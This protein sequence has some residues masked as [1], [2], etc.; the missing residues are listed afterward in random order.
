M[1]FFLRVTHPTGGHPRVLI[2]SM[3]LIILGG[4]VR[5]NDMGQLKPLQGVRFM[6]VASLV[7]AF[8]IVRGGCVWSSA[9]HRVRIRRKRARVYSYHTIPLTIGAGIE[10]YKNTVRYVVGYTSA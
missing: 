5:N 8:A 7:S 3:I 2:G 6:V 1:V 4:G 9:R 10:V